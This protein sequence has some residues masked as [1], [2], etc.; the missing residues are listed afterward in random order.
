MPAANRTA[1]RIDTPL[2]PPPWAVMQ[3]ALLQAQAPALEA[4]Y[5][6]ALDRAG[7]PI[8]VEGRFKPGHQETSYDQML[9][10]FAEYND[11]VG[12]HPLNL[13]TTTLA[14]NA[15]SLVM[16]AGAYGEHRFGTVAAG[17]T[18]ATVDRSCLTVHLEPGCGARLVL[19]QHRYSERPTFTFPWDRDE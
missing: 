13:R 12:D 11:V 14:L 10:H 18:R 7:D 19:E 17:T 5:A 1:I 9:A 15:R 4:F 8:E 3:R 6:N 16:Q 2:L